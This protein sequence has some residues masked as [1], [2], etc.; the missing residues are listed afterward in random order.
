MLTKSLGIPVASS[1]NPKAGASKVAQKQDNLF[2]IFKEFEEKMEMGFRLD[3]QMLNRSVS[4]RRDKSTGAKTKQSFKKVQQK[5]GS[6]DIARASS[7]PNAFMKKHSQ[8]LPSN[9]GAKNVSNHMDRLV[10]ELTAKETKMDAKNGFEA[11]QQRQFAQLISKPEDLRSQLDPVSAASEVSPKLRLSNGVTH[12]N[13]STT[14][15]SMQ[16]NDICRLKTLK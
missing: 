11:E 1:L 7:L 14:S 9:P 3:K 8:R 6:A 15:D 5:L 12:K 13:L 2:K 16:V 10:H 4:V